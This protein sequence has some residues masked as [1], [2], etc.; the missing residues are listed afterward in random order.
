HGRVQ[1][2]PHL[3]RNAGKSFGLGVEPPDAVRPVLRT[4]D[5][6]VPIRID[7]VRAGQ[8]A[9]GHRRYM[10]F[11]DS[12]GEGI[13]PA[14][15]GAAVSRVPEVAFGIAGYVMGRGLEPWQLVFSDNDL[16]RAGLRTR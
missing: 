6:V 10:E 2:L 7:P 12:A 15:I 1:R 13:E 9:F 11:L 8:H 4:P 16:G 3:P 5:D 14:D